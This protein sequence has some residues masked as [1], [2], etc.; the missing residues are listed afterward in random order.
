[1]VQRQGGIVTTILYYC[2][3]HTHTHAHTQHT[4]PH[5]PGDKV[6]N[7]A[8]FAGTLAGALAHL[9]KR[10][11][12]AQQVQD[13]AAGVA[14]VAHTEPEE[15]PLVKR[16]QAHALRLA[17]VLGYI[18]GGDSHLDVLYLRGAGQARNH[19]RAARP[20]SI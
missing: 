7:D 15:E 12:N 19:S 3:A 9:Q 17:V 20:C 2:Y 11:V 5:T 13:A 16:L 10:S 4:H 1:M 8:T 6:L 14:S 18:G